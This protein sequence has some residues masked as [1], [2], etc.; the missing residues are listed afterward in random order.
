VKTKPDRS[1]FLTV[2][3]CAILV[4]AVLVSAASAQRDWI[5]D[6]RSG[7][8][9]DS[10]VSRS[11]RSADVLDD[12]AWK[13]LIA[14]GQGFQLTDDLRLGIFGELES[15]VWAT[16]SGLNSVSPGVAPNLRYRFG[17]GKNAPWV[18]LETKVA[19]FGSSEARRS[20]WE[21][22]SALRAGISLSE[23][24]SLEAA[25]RYRHFDARD[26]RFDQDSHSGSVRGR[27]EI[28]SSTQVALGYTY[29]H[30]DVNSHA[31]PPR[32][33]IVAIARAFGPVDTFDT[34]Y[35]AYR[36]AATTHSTSIAINHALNSFAA[37]QATY[38]WQRTTH[39]ALQYT[40]HVAELG[41]ALTF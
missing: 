40:N 14:A 39:E 28:A 32:P 8:L 22:P 13:S 6:A 3:R 36:F 4:L 27:L 23:R 24:L 5:V 33:D 37:V 26:V 10:N 1:G 38:E 34:P 15:H 12:A 29:R 11:N 30:G 9:Y 31:V 7:V 20:G 25:Y 35:V 2:S 19:Y 18:R 41:I 21:I 16:Y 17:L